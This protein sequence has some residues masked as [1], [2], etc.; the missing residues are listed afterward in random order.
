MNYR[1]LFCK[2]DASWPVVIGSLILGFSLY[3]FLLLVDCF[4]WVKGRRK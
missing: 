2:A 1:A 3:G 4:M